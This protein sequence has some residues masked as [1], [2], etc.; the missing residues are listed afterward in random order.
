MDGRMD[1]RTDKLYYVSSFSVKQVTDMCDRIENGRMDGGTDDRTV[2]HNEL[3]C[4][5]GNGRT[6]PNWNGQMDGL[7]ENP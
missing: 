1:G 2:Q 4:E 7:A 3:L 6:P 5:E